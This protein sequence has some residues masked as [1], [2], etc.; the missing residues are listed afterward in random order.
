[1]STGSHSTAAA[2]WAASPPRFLVGMT[3]EIS[4]T[5]GSILPSPG[6][7]PAH[8]RAQR[9]PDAHISPAV[10]VFRLPHRLRLARGVPQVPCSWHLP[11][12]SRKGAR[13]DRLPETSDMDLRRILALLIS[14]TLGACSGAR[15]SLL[16]GAQTIS[17]E[18]VPGE[19]TL[20]V[21]APLAFECVVAGAEDGECTWSVE[22]GA[23]GGQ[24]TSDGVYTAPAEPGTFRVVAAAHADPSRTA[25]AAVTVSALSATL[26]L[27]VSPAAVSLTAG[28]P[29]PFG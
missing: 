13:T 29:P 16:D 4:G 18:V 10:R 15:G 14:F 8:L 25:A 6:A 19:T 3:I 1:M 21:G 2:G 12:E 22:E 23:A 24:I 11:G 28:S 7:G 9:A 26:I 17:V 27:L 20:V 5:S